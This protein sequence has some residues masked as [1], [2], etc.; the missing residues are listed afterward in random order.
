MIY[1]SE[2]SLVYEKVSYT[3]QG[4]GERHLQVL[5]EILTFILLFGGCFSSHYNL[6]C[7]LFAK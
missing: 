7:P 3:E 2:M 5:V 1:Y 6:I 4:F